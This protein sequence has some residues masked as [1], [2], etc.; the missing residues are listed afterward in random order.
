MQDFDFATETQRRVDGVLEA[1]AIEKGVD[2]AKLKSMAIAYLADMASEP[3][4]VD[5]SSDVRTVNNSTSQQY[6]VLSETEKTQVDALKELGAMF[7]GLCHEIG[8]T[9]P[10][11]ERAGSRKLSLAITHAE[12]A[13]MRAVRH[14]T[15]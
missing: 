11:G 3:V 9:D 7:I 2:V 5:A 6:R 4:T 13:V 15:A 8:G 14:V 10:D 1:L 12:D